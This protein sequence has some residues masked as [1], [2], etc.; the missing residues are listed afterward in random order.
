VNSGDLP[1]YRKLVAQLK[2]WNP[3]H[4]YT[5]V[6]FQDAEIAE[7]MRTR[8]CYQSIPEIQELLS[9]PDTGGF[10]GVPAGDRLTMQLNR[11]T[12]AET[13]YVYFVSRA[14]MANIVSSVETTILNWALQLEVD[15]VLGDGLSFTS[16]ERAAAAE[17]SY[18]VTNFYGPVS[19]AQVQQASPGAL[20]SKL[21][22]ESVETL[23]DR[24]E[25]ELDRH[26]ADE[27]TRAEAVSDIRTIRAQLDS[28]RPK[29]SVIRASLHS[30]Q[31]VLESAAGGGAAYL[32]IEIGKLP[33]G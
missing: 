22:V 21:D 13:H 3:F 2:A 26:V 4:G 17:R 18:D 27:E 10:L 9:H 30:L 25:K 8:P 19:T 14:A 24:V 23:I 1:P 7:V 33:A 29:E 6:H 16:E 12:L 28:P 31:R 15:G 32:V 11:V 20:Q 5:H